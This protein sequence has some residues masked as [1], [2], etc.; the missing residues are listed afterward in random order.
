[1]RHRAGRS[2]RGW[3]RFGPRRHGRG[4]ADRCWRRRGSA[5]SARPRGENARRN[6]GLRRQRRCRRRPGGRARRRPRRVPALRRDWRRCG[7]GQGAPHLPLR[8]ATVRVFASGRREDSGDNDDH[9]QY[10]HSQHSPRYPPH[11]QALPLQQPGSICRMAYLAL[12]SRDRARAP[13]RSAA[14]T[15][16]T[17]AASLSSFVARLNWA[18]HMPTVQQALNSGQL[19]SARSITTLKDLQCN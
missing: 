19:A 17:T 15:R 3:R 4:R 18:V 13:A 2:S 5:S 12:R 6:R 7:C 9:A 14:A 16:P 1:M 11:N 8:C 10:R